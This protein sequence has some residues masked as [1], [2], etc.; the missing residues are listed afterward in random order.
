M[1]GKSKYYILHYLLYHKLG[2]MEDHLNKK[3][4]HFFSF[5]HKMDSRS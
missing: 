5:I 3:Q 4:V 2:T 1:M